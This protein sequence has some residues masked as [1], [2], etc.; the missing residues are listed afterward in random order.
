M[1]I[2]DLF[3]YLG[4]GLLTILLLIFM[5]AGGIAFVRSHELTLCSHVWQQRF[6]ITDVVTFACRNTRAP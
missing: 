1:P 2:G 4:C 5:I 3:R 6:N